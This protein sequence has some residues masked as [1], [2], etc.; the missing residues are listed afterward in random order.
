MKLSPHNLRF[1]AEF[2]RRESGIVVSEDKEYLIA[3]RLGP[4]AKRAGKKSVDDLLSDL[5]TR[6]TSALRTEVIEAM[7]TNETTFFRD[8]HPFNAL[9]EQLLPDILEANRAE[10]ELSIWSAAASTGQEAYTVSILLRE[11]F[12][13]LQDWKVR[14]VASDISEDVLDRARDGRY[15]QHEV[16][17]GLPTPL[18]RK[19]FE[20][21]GDD[22]VVHDTVRKSVEF[23]R[24]NLIAPFP[25]S[26][27][28]FDI[29]LLRNVLIYFDTDTKR[30]ILRRVRRVM[31]PHAVV[32]L[33]AA[34]TTIGIDSALERVE[35]DHT[36]VY[37][38]QSKASE[39]RYD[40]RN[41]AVQTPD[42]SVL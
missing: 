10:R 15:Q 14:I 5:R 33:G 12:P 37:R 17:R 19:Y 21:S 29:V 7:T 22:W 36:S 11:S 28:A 3:S 25:R 16:N 2:L 34:E 23:L 13:E 9:Q 1:F 8:L 40:L 32:M 26:L 20:R 30:D 35:L 41:R 24:I 18:L 38:I 39:S 27:P 31:K 42:Q 4:L 6:S